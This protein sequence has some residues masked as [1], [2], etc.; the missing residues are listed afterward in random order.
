MIIALH[1]AVQGRAR[2]TVPGLKGS[3]ALKRAIEQ[4]LVIEP[5]IL[6]AAANPVT[7][8]LLVHFNSNNDHR[9]IAYLIEGVLAEVRDGRRPAAGPKAA[10]RKRARAVPVA[11][12]KQFLALPEEPNRRRRS[13]GTPWPGTP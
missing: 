5:E 7:G 9:T 12:L 1:T 11:T 13:L 3:D 2:Y 10:R 6:T 8:S 4:R